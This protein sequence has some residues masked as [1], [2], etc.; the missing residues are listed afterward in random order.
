MDSVSRSSSPWAPQQAMVP[1]ALSP[2]VWNGPAE[3][4]TNGMLELWA[5]LATVVASGR[6][7]ASWV[8]SATVVA[9]GCSVASWDGVSAGMVGVRPSV[10]CA[11]AGKVGSWAG[12]LACVD[13]GPLLASGS[14][15]AAWAQPANTSARVAAVRQRIASPELSRRRETVMFCFFLTL[16]CLLGIAQIKLI[17]PTM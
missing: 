17:P 4:W 2:Q 11:P 9:S 1:S 13:V 7:V 6:S 8:G 3:T 15:V 16:G 12:C 14:G 5:G 10:S